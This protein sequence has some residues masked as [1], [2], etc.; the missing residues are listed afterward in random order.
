MREIGRHRRTR[1]PD[2]KHDLF[3]LGDQ[4]KPGEQPEQVFAK[5]LGPVRADPLQLAGQ[6]VGRGAH[7]RLQL[8][9]QALAAGAKAGL[10]G[11]E[12]AQTVDHLLV[13][14]VLHQG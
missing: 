8:V 2:P 5:E 6:R 4:V 9:E 1:A 11:K 7:R 10:G 14:G 12:L 3:F 13:L